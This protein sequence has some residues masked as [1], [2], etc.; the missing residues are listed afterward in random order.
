MIS[1]WSK[2][3]ACRD[4]LL[5]K[6][7]KT[8]KHTLYLFG[9]QEDTKRTQIGG[10][11]QPST[12]KFFCNR[13]S[14]INS[15]AFIQILFQVWIS[16]YSCWYLVDFIW[17]DPFLPSSK[18]TTGLWTM[19]LA[20]PCTDMHGTPARRQSP[21]GPRVQTYDKRFFVFEL[22]AA[23]S[24][25]TKY[26]W[27]ELPLC[28]LGVG[29]WWLGIWGKPFRWSGISGHWWPLPILSPMAHTHMPH[30][31][32]PILPGL[33]LGQIISVSS[34]LWRGEH[35]LVL[36][37]EASDQTD[38]TNCILRDCWPANHS[39]SAIFMLLFC[40]NG[41]NCNCL[42]P[43]SGSYQHTPKHLHISHVFLSERSGTHR[44]VENDKCQALPQ[45][46]K[47]VH[48]SPHKRL[49]FQNFIST[50]CWGYHPCLGVKPNSM[51]F[52][53]KKG[54]AIKIPKQH[55]SW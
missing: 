29:G 35:Q 40:S 10:L 48:K 12:R 16:T 17:F 27:T 13:N 32:S 7:E 14:W 38:K 36:A 23:V 51:W 18:L 26:L 50:K 2:H 55:C 9:F 8:W 11:E 21:V 41:E 28:R 37:G 5:W 15:E 25:Q 24:L 31:S 20:L 43:D 33:L 39:N 45:D 30:A 1:W 22:L 4:G 47:L 42:I 44:M 6:S 46:L 52:C 34:S 19:E 53:A 49:R 54:T 3:L